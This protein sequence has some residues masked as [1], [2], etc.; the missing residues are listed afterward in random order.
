MPP[1]ASLCLV[2]L[3]GC[4]LVPEVAT[5]H[6]TYTIRGTH[7]QQARYW[8]DPCVLSR[9]QKSAALHVHELANIRCGELTIIVF[10][11]RKIAQL[12]SSNQRSE[13]QSEFFG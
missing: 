5:H 8:M 9:K 2:T 10:V 13:F 6:Y 12:S 7:R 3:I 4:R 1:E 11:K